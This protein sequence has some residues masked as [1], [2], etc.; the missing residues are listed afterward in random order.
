MKKETDSRR[1]TLKNRAIAI[2]E[3]VRKLLRWD[4]MQYNTFQY[5]CGLAYLKQYL[6][7]DEY[8]A[9]EISKSANF[10]AWWRNHWMQRDLAFMEFEVN[11]TYTLDELRD[12]FRDM[13]DAE[14]LA[15]AIYPNG[16]ILSDSYARM[17]TEVVEH[18]T[19]KI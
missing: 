10:W 9:T 5:E 17:I 14:T 8:M 6:K 11:T 15:Q 12:F 3:A 2:S 19:Q 13:H 7:G 4:E 18:E 1:T 16:V